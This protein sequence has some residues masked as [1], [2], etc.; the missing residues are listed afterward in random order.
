[1][2]KPKAYIPPYKVSEDAKVIRLTEMRKLLDEG[3]YAERQEEIENL[4]GL[5]SGEE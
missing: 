1:M 4:Y 2:K 5:L 3:T